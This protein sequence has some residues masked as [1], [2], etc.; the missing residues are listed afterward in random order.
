VAQFVNWR[1]SPNKEKTL[2]IELT[3]DEINFIQQVLG[4]LPS[5]TGAFLV[6]NAIAKQ[7]QEAA[8]FEQVKQSAIQG[9]QNV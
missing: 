8:Q 6:M 7:V 1:L 4:E 5:K 2:K 9:E 3:N